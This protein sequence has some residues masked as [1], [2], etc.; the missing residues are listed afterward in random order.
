MA[1][2]LVPLWAA[3]LAFGVFMCKVK[4]GSGYR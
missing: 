4:A 2:D 3:I 1:L